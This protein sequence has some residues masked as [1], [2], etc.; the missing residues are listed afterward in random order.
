MKATIRLAG[1]LAALAVAAPAVA[2]TSNGTGTGRLQATRA[3]LE[4]TLTQYQQAGRADEAGLIQVRL[5]DG[6]FRVGD[7]ITMTVTGQEALT[8]D[9]LVTEGPGGPQLELPE[10]G[11]VSLAGLLRSE[12]RDALT[13]HISQY[14]RD[15]QVIV[16]THVRLAVF[17][18]VGSPGYHIVPSD[19]LLTDV[20]MQAGGPA[21]EAN[22]KK[23]KIRRGDDVIW[24]GD[25]LQVAMVEGRT[26]DQLNLRA[27]DEVQVPGGSSV[28]KIVRGAAALSS[29]VFLVTRIVNLF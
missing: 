7:Q 11:A 15:P 16:R 19:G 13:H 25:N 26:V 17:G 14:V 22:Q 4:A 18:E 1:V 21:G 6:D 5:R 23:I 24:E 28:W 20:I 3:D 9:F 8:E 2:Q 27:G 29:A 10:I 12:L